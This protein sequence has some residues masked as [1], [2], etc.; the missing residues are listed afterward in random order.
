M[1][2]L[3]WATRNDSQNNIE[4]WPATGITFSAAIQK[5]G[6]LEL[7]FQCVPLTAYTGDQKATVAAI[8][9]RDY[10]LCKA[11]KKILAE[12]TSDEELLPKIYKEL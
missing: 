12:D 5:R 11:W 4:N 6:N 10:P 8:V 2:T 9:H 7:L 1:K 3:G